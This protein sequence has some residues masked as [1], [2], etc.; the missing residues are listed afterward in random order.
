MRKTYLIHAR[1]VDGVQDNAIE[2]GIL[3]ISPL[4]R[5][6]GMTK[7]PLSAKWRNTPTFPKR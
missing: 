5:A 7:S 4:R 6:V 1:I 3:V 2:D